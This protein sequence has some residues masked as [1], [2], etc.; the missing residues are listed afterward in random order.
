ML[1]REKFYFTNNVP[2]HFEQMPSHLG[3]TARFSLS[4]FVVLFLPARCANGDRFAGG[5]KRD[6]EGMAVLKR[7]LCNAVTD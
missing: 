2:V 6:E 1:V 4:E 5:G 3:R 7:L